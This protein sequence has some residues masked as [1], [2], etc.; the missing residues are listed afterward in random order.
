MLDLG[1]I[2]E[3]LESADPTAGVEYPNEEI[4]QRGNNAGINNLPSTGRWR[5]LNI[6]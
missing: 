2:L 3:W 5:F 4:I 1:R 6:S